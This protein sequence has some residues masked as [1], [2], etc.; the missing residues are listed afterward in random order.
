MEIVENY[1]SPKLECVDTMKGIVFD[2]KCISKLQMENLMHSL[3]WKKRMQN[4]KRVVIIQTEFYKIYELPDKK[5]FAIA[6]HAFHQNFKNFQQHIPEFHLTYKV[7][8]GKDVTYTTTIKLEPPQKAVCDYLVDYFKSGPPNRPTASSG[9]QG[10]VFVM[11]AGLGKSFV[12]SKIIERLQ[13]KTLLVVMNTN[14]LQQWKADVFGKYFSGVTIGEYSAKKKADGDIVIVIIKSLIKLEQNYLKEFG[15]V[16]FDEIPE[17]MG[18][19]YREAFWKTNTQYVLGLTATPDERL[20]GMDIFYKQ[21]VGPLVRATDIEGFNVEQ[22]IWKGRVKTIRY[23]GPPQFTKN[24]TSVTNEMSCTMMN[25]QFSQDPY[26]CQLIYNYIVELYNAGKNVYIF[27][28]NRDHLDNMCNIIRKS[29]IDF[30]IEDEEVPSEP[31]EDKV[32]LGAITKVKTLMGGVSDAE[33]VEAKKKSRIIFTTYSYGAVG[34]SIIKMDAI[35]FMTSR[36]NKMRQILGRILRRGG[37]PSIV[38]DIIDIVDY[39]TGIKSQYYKRK[40]IYEEKDF[41][42][43]V[44]DV[45][46]SSITLKNFTL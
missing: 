37:D 28:T 33:V 32:R 20:D 25:Q 4:G 42:I 6:R 18:P 1:E 11:D 24:L 27:A 23:T 7:P 39:S 12:A 19:S 26:R 31:E 10:C 43:E 15:L 44:I 34:M 9:P 29:N 38:R 45:D 16:I 2:L 30:T 40:K 46:Y 36:K 5:L 41:P 14:Q 22:I 35:I 21:L 17:F 13:K 8:K 3:T